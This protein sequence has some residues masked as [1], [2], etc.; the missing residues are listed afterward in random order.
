MWDVD[1]YLMNDDIVRS[2]NIMRWWHRL[3]KTRM[4]TVLSS[5]TVWNHKKYGKERD[6]QGNKNHGWINGRSEL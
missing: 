6:K 4:T 1:I 2:I 3:R 5:R